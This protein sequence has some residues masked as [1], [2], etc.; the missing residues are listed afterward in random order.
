[1]LERRVVQISTNCIESFILPLYTMVISSDTGFDIG[2]QLLGDELELP[3]I[4]GTEVEI[5]RRQRLI[6]K[7][8]Q[9]TSSPARSFS[10]PW[11]VGLDCVA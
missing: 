6:R 4:A 5:W 2:G 1:M 3:R 7:T 11:F 9:P 8:S 10:R